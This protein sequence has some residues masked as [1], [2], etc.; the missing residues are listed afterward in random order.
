M[1]EAR[2][3]RLHPVGVHLQGILEKANLEDGKQ[4]I[5]W[6]TLGKGADSKGAGGYV[7][8]VE[9]LDLDHRGRSLEGIQQPQMFVRIDGTMHEK[10]KVFSI[11]STL[12]KA[13]LNKLD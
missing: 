1:R 8:V 13:Y 3:K 5:G 12:Y 4:V 10:V 7:W 9:L 11:K 6:P 2:L